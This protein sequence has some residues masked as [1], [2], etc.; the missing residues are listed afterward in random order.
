MKIEFNKDELALLTAMVC[1]LRVDVKNGILDGDDELAQIAKEAYSSL[2]TKVLAAS[3]EIMMDEMS[4]GAM[5][6]E[7]L[8]E[9]E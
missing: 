9:E 4:E 6:A 5:D 2:Q 3:F 8:D 1:A 7:I